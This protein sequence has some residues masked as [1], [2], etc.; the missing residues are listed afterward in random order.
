MVR[1]GGLVRNGFEGGSFLCESNRV[2]L[3]VVKGFI[4]WVCLN[5]PKR[6]V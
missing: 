3:R 5:N 2:V 4:E 1:W 6:V